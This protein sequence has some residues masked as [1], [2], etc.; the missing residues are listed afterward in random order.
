MNKVRCTY[1]FEGPNIMYNHKH[2]KKNN[3]YSADFLGVERR[4]YYSI[5]SCYNL[6]HQTLVKYIDLNE[7]VSEHDLETFTFFG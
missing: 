7:F 1:I 5:M 4:K 6:E 3:A 2:E